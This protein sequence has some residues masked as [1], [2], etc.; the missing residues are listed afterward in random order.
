[1]AMRKICPDAV[2]GWRSR[3]SRTQPVP[4]IAAC[5]AG[6]MRTAKMASAGALMV[7]LTLIVALATA[8]DSCLMCWN[9][10]ECHTQPE[11][12][13]DL[14]DVQTTGYRLRSAGYVGEDHRP[15]LKPLLVGEPEVEH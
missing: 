8:T 12:Q 15:V 3:G 7:M 2:R 4:S 1:M 5:F 9:Q 6:S 13:V 10:Y 11:L 14:C